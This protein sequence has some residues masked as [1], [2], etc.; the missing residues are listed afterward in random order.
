M[1]VPS[2]E[3]H[4]P[5]GGN[6]GQITTYMTIEQNFGSLHATLRTKESEGMPGRDQRKDEAGRAGLSWPEP[7]VARCRLRLRARL[8]TRYQAL[9]AAAALRIN[10]AAAATSQGQ[11]MSRLSTRLFQVLYT[12]PPQL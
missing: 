3:S 6:R 8:A 2:P 4:I 9:F 10:S 11:T 7:G 5:E 1:L 12:V